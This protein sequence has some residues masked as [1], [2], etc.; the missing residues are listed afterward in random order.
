MKK[1]STAVKWWK[2]QFS[3]E[4]VLTKKSNEDVKNSTKY[5]IYNNIY[6]DDK[7]VVASLEN[8]TVWHIEIVISMLN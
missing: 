3:K 7:V 5:W 8:I 6:V 4:L 1:V 2:K